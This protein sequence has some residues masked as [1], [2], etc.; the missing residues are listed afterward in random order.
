M[1][2]SWHLSGWRGGGRR[3]L[4]GVP[5]LQLIVVQSLGSTPLL[6]LAGRQ[7]FTLVRPTQELLAQAKEVSDLLDRLPSA[8]LQSGCPEEAQGGKL[9]GSLGSVGYLSLRVNEISI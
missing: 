8:V 3:L 9:G 2:E 4:C 7:Q 6:L 1:A 5:L